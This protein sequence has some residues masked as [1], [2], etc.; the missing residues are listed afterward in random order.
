MFSPAPVPDRHLTA[1]RAPCEKQAMA[2]LRVSGRGA[3]I[4]IGWALAA[5]ACS[6]GGGG[7]VT[8]PQFYDLTSAPGAIALAASAVVRVHTAGEYGSGSFISPDGLLLTNNHVLGD[9]VCPLEGCSIELTFD[10]QRG[11]TYTPPVTVFA[12]PV[13]VDVGLDMAL[14]Q[15]ETGGAG[16]PHLATP[17]YLTI[18][19][20]DPAS[21]MGMHI[22]IVGH[23]ESRLKKWTSGQVV[24]VFGNWFSS[25]AYILPGDSGSPVLDDA[26]NLVG[27]IHRA[28]TGEDLIS[29]DGVNVMAI[30]TASGPLQASMAAA[31]L[32]SSMISTAAATTADAVVANDFVYLNGLASTAP[33]DGAITDVLSVL[34]TACDAALART[35]F[36]SPDDLTSATQPCND[37]LEWIECRLD[38]GHV[39]YGTVC[40][41]ADAALW[42]SRFQKLNALWVAMNGNTDLS[43]VTFG[44][45]QLSSSVANGTQAGNAGLQAALTAAGNPPLDFGIEVYLA[46]FDLTS[47]AQTDTLTWLRGY[48]QTPGYQD[49]GLSIAFAYLWWWDNNA[50]VE[51]EAL[52]ALSQLNHD[53]TVSISAKLYADQVLYEN[54][55]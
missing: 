5:A 1:S 14:V 13:A 12:V 19:G 45:A 20:H 29:S 46:A 24:D 7:G 8:L 4:G 15:I 44:V 36:A 47:Y 34:G 42:T 49:Y 35:D 30:G 32:P 37:A 16:S 39:P 2:I 11:K 55:K 9:T 53:P 25:T 43:P 22:N 6:S 31:A 23:P 50:V 54:G 33:V 51:S 18:V 3:A 41:S 38:A 52:D 17:D 27:L 21:L 40:P 10:F 28:P 26:G 48:R